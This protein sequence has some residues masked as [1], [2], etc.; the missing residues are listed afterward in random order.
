MAHQND[1]EAERA[2]KDTGTSNHT[3]FGDAKQ[4][5][6]AGNVHNTGG[7]NFA[8]NNNVAAADVPDTIDWLSQLTPLNFADKQLES[9][10]EARKTPGTGERLL[11]TEEF[12]RWRDC[13]DLRTLW[14]HGIPGAGKTILCSVVIDSL[15]RER[16]DN[17]TTA[18]LYVY[19]DHRD[20]RRQDFNNVLPC[21]LAQ[22][23]RQRD[24]VSKE[25]HQLH[26]SSRTKGI[27]PI[28]DDYLK[29]LASE[30]KKLHKVYIVVD[31]LDE[32]QG[33]AELNTRDDFV[34]A[35]QRLPETTTR[36]LFFSR[37]DESINSLVNPDDTI[38][39]AAN[40]SEL[41]SYVKRR[42]DGRRELKKLVQ[43]KDDEIRL[44]AR[45]TKITVSET[46]GTVSFLEQ[47]VRKVVERSDGMF[48]LARLHMDF[49]ASK[50]TAQEL[51]DGLKTLPKTPDEVY[52]LALQRIAEQEP[53]R[54]ALAIETLRWLVFAERALTMPELLDALAVDTV[55]SSSNRNRQKPNGLATEDVITSVCAGL[56]VVN[57]D[58]NNRSVSLAHYTTRTYVE[59]HA[60]TIFKPFGNSQTILAE[61]CL[62]YLLSDDIPGPQLPTSPNEEK[63]EKEKP[64]FHNYAA[65]YWGRHM[66]AISGNK[67][68]R[69]DIHK[70]AQDLLYEPDAVTRAFQVMTDPRFRNERAICPLHVAAYFGLD[71]LTS[72]LIRRGSELDATTTRGETALHWSTWYGHSAVVKTLI[73]NGASPNIK[74][75][76]AQTPLLRAIM[77]E[78]MACFAAILLSQK[79]IETDIE[80]DRGWTPLRWA[81]CH[82]QLAIVQALLNHGA[83]INAKDRDGFT[84][85]HW[86]NSYGHGRIAELLIDRGALLGDVSSQLLYASR[87]GQLG[88][89]RRILEMTSLHSHIRNRRNGTSGG[90]SSRHPHPRRGGGAGVDMNV[91]DEQG[92]TSLR[93]AVEDGH[94][95]VALYLLQAGADVSKAD[96]QGLAPLHAAAAAWATT[97]T[98]PQA[99][100]FAPLSSMAKL[101]NNS[102]SSS[103]TPWLLLQCGADPLQRTKRGWTP[104]HFACNSQ[105]G[106]PELVWLL[107]QHTPSAISVQTKHGETP[108]HLACRHGHL[109]IVSLLLSRGS[110]PLREVLNNSATAL[111]VAV[112]AGQ[113]EVVRLLLSYQQHGEPDILRKLLRARDGEHATALHYA[114]STSPPH[115]SSRTS[116]FQNGSN[117]EVVKERVAAIEIIQ[118]LVTTVSF[119]ERDT[120]MT[121][122]ALEKMVNAR[123]RYGNT[124]LHKAARA[125]RGDIIHHLIKEL[126]ADPNATNRRGQTPLHLA[127]ET[128]NL[129][130]VKVFLD[131]NR[132][133]S[134]EGDET[135]SKKMNRGTGDDI[136]KLG[137]NRQVPVDTTIR[138][139]RGMTAWEIMT[140]MG[141]GVA[142]F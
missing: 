75:N 40:E 118:L 29:V 67:Q 70:L 32:C 83:D 50:I 64:H 100:S 61:T 136:S 3:N 23:V 116:T 114:A 78:D 119:N 124:P 46:K 11:K 66:A 37:H 98:N 25:V 79:K 92:R 59:T 51:E 84:A 117:Q 120:T 28:P 57:P 60:S 55:G 52:K 142:E 8:I 85:L 132:T 42:I 123:D 6:I 90:K 9:I 131:I 1:R 129:S 49:L 4:S 95:M 133:V 127:A 121:T 22:L 33:D 96:E 17:G 36:L 30:I 93:L 82:G 128:G 89:V 27:P 112:E 2:V 122:A 13:D 54:H 16:R 88:L 31:A 14:C 47:V 130:V 81:A 105:V 106:S 35:L 48:L 113:F 24:E 111:H 101:A 139:E 134:K 91:T 104:L 102:T 109:S 5:I 115:A 18:C 26:Q 38:S 34:C 107:L 68:Q 137:S 103:T 43:N 126:D 58:S 74:D 7:I 65:D 138:D 94:G 77:R 135:D 62:W 45:M 63:P 80:D 53:A 71:R 73:T 97:T 86:A 108:L 21:L 140:D 39:I 20:Q 72:K 87:H 125:E 99:T 110:D 15:E 76:K 44:A 19:F 69:Q 12:C 10:R 41:A 56:L 141:Y